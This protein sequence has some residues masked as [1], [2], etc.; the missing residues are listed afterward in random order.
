MR[1]ENTISSSIPLSGT[2]R[3]YHRHLGNNPGI[4]AIS[5]LYI[6]LQNIQFLRS[7]W[8]LNVTIHELFVIGTRSSTHVV[9]I[10]YN[11]NFV[12]IWLGLLFEGEIAKKHNT[13]LKTEL[14]VLLAEE[15]KKQ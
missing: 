6:F 11:I 14:E 3:L 15:V 9:I 10:S 1:G 8:Y 2:E 13:L 12:K 4:S 7:V 5:T